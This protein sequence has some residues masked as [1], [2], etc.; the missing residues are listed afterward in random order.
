[1]ELADS[2]CKNK[3]ILDVNGFLNSKYQLPGDEIDY[4]H[5]KIN[6]NQNLKHSALSTQQLSILEIKI[7]DYTEYAE[8]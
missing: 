3:R 5:L 1:M 6:H 7:L 8:A 4:K 2:K